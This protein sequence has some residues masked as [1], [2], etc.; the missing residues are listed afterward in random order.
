MSRTLSL[1]SSRR[2][3]NFIIYAA[4]SHRRITFSEAHPHSHM[5]RVLC[6]HI[7]FCPY[8]RRSYQLHKSPF[9]LPR[10]I[11]CPFAFSLSKSK[12]HFR[13]WR[14]RTLV[15]LLRI[16]VDVVRVATTPHDILQALRYKD[17]SLCSFRY[18]SPKWRTNRSL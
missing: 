16:Y 14:I 8:S 15:V 12:Y 1:A 7:A 2:S 17:A 13:W 10:Y 5:C 6:I 4:L 9:V 18:S 3:L 11:E